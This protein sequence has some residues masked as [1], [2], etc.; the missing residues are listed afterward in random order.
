MF[1]ESLVAP[2]A[3]SVCG[4]LGARGDFVV[5][6]LGFG[7]RVPR[8]PPYHALPP[9]DERAGICRRSDHLMGCRFGMMTGG[10]VSMTGHRRTRARRVA[11]GEPVSKADSPRSGSA[12]PSLDAG[13]HTRILTGP[14]M[15][16]A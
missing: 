2:G 15:A 5:A 13:E 11:C 12:Q 6:L 10:T 3:P 16:G 9:D 4:F 14:T 8:W 1:T 7:R